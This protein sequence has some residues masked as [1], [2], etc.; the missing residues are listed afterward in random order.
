LLKLYKNTLRSAIKQAT[1]AALSALP[2]T[3]ADEIA[4]ERL[5]GTKD[6]LE[7]FVDLFESAVDQVIKSIEYKNKQSKTNTQ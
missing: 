6:I 5:L 4:R 7:P 3:K 2:E 1:D